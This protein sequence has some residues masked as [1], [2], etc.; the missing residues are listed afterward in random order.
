[1]PLDECELAGRQGGGWQG[2][3]LQALSQSAKELLRRSRGA[4]S[5]ALKARTVGVEVEPALDGALA[6][7]ARA[8]VLLSPSPALE[9]E[10]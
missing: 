6:F 3:A 4:A 10:A 2:K 7:N 5:H 9:M 8:Q 1:M